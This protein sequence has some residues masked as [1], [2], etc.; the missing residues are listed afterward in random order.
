[1]NLVFKVLLKLSNGWDGEVE[2]D[3]FVDKDRMK[4]VMCCINIFWVFMFKGG[5]KLIWRVY[6]KCIFME[7]GM[8]LGK[9]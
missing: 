2:Y 9:F 8:K 6:I 1:M 3:R 5:Y 4:M 7:N